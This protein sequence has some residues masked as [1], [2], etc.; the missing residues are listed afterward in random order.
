MR[1]TA[2]ALL[3]LASCHD[4]GPAKPVNLN[5]K[6][7]A[8]L[9]LE[10]HEYA[11]DADVVV[12]VDLVNSTP[13]PIEVMALVLESPQ[14]LLEVTDTRGKRVDPVPPPV[15]RDERVKIAPGE[16]KTV[17]VTLAIFSPHLPS[18][19]YLVAPAPGVAYGNPAQF[20]IQ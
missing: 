8:T 20:H 1:C 18:G 13:N 11:K 3:A 5:T 2:L 10:R 9:S 16:H 17:K 6:L 15:P 4:E 14:L 19:D 12:A 7:T